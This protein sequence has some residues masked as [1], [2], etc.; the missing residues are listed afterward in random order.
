V[1][2]RELREWLGITFADLFDYAAIAVVA[3]MF[4][5]SDPMVDVV[6]AVLGVALALV[7][8]PL[9]MKRDPELSNFT[10]SAK[11]VT[12]PAVVLLVVGAIVVHY[13]RFNR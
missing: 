6:L 1:A 11:L 4:F 10:N 12:Y 2:S 13:I 7:A 8:C 3:A 5:V 9:G